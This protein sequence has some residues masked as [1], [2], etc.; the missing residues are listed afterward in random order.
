M[1]S[2]IFQ[3]LYIFTAFSNEAGDEIGCA[4]KYT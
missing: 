4:N 2:T 3:P 1:K